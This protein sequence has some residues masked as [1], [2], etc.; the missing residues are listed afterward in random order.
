MSQE[1]EKQLPGKKLKKFQKENVYNKLL[2]YGD[3]LE[4]ESAKLFADIK[5]NL[6]KS[7]L[8]REMRPGSALWTSRLN[9]YV[10]FLIIFIKKKCFICTW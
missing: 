1:R 5:S 10:F 6:I 8:A 7:V 4:E 3:E 9:K 2:P